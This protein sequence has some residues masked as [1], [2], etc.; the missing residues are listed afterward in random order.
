MEH[1]ADLRITMYV[2][3]TEMTTDSL[4]SAANDNVE[5]LHIYYIDGRI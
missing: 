3:R 1:T 4:I 5:R 2:C